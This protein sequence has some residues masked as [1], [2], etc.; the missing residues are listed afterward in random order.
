LTYFISILVI[1]PEGEHEL[2]EVPREINAIVR[3]LGIDEGE[4]SELYDDSY[5]IFF[6]TFINIRYCLENGRFPAKVIVVSVHKQKNRFDF[7]KYYKS[8]TENEAFKLLGKLKLKKEFLDKRIFPSG[9]KS[10]NESIYSHITHDRRI[11]MNA[12]VVCS[13]FLMH[14]HRITVKEIMNCVKED[15]EVIYGALLELMKKKIIVESLVEKGGK[16]YCLHPDY[17]EKADRTYRQFYN[18]ALLTCTNE[19]I[20]DKKSFASHV[21]SVKENHEDI[22]LEDA[23]ALVTEMQTASVSMLQRRFRI[24]YTRA[25]RIIDELELLNIVGPYEG[26]KPRVVL[27]N[28][29]ASEAIK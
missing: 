25:A 18:E 6:P 26:S 2:K 24:G 4:L 19:P 8:L 13:L 20:E 14:E 3:E 29:E 1:N 17:I 10:L 5:S 23:I 22:L 11:S 28:R 12:K 27:I 16:G 15:Q 9:S 21:I 7:E